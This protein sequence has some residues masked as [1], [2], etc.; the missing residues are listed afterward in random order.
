MPL[1]PAVA[2]W[3][4]G[5][6]SVFTQGNI[7]SVI[8]PSCLPPTCINDLIQDGSGIP[9]LAIGGSSAAVSTGTGGISSKDWIAKSTLTGR[10]PDYASFVSLIP[11]SITPTD[12]GASCGG[13]TFNT[14]GAT[15]GDGYYWYRHNG[16]VTIT[17]DVAL[18]AGRKVI[19][20]VDGNLT[21]NGKI[22][23]NPANAYFMPIVK[24]N[25]TVDGAVTTPTGTPT[26]TGIFY[27]DGKF[28]SSVGTGP[29]SVLGSV[30][31][32]GGVSLQ[33]DLGAGNNFASSEN[34]SISPDLMLNYPGELS[35]KRPVWHEV[36]P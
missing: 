3:Q 4:S 22:T 14:G 5:N 11:V 35:F 12:T 34:F 10:V 33:R 23:Y 16:D 20:Y 2:W 24:G 15:T 25:I 27:C 13:A 29:L 21:I 1:C 7:Q 36:A 31:A 28:D 32:K 26:L 18:N 19:L 30:V 9:G 8:P 17:S 6:G